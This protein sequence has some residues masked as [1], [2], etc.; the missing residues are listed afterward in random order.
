MTSPKT[1]IFHPL[2]LENIWKFWAHSAWGFFCICCYNVN[3]ALLTI[4]VYEKWL[5]VFWKN[6]KPNC[7]Q[8]SIGKGKLNLSSKWGNAKK[9]QNR[10]CP[11]A[12]SCITVLGGLCL[13]MKGTKKQNNNNNNN[14]KQQRQKTFK[15][16]ISTRSELK[17]V[18]VL[19]KGM[20]FKLFTKGNKIPL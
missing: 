19:T 18:K 5:I 16:E 4:P 13:V 20:I 11:P 1:V 2:S 9:K 3:Q 12:A 8:H 15:G 6:A 10:N 17:R 7:V 14:K